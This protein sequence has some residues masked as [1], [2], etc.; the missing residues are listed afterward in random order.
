MREN[1]SENRLSELRKVSLEI[2]EELT[3]CESELLELI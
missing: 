3:H 2:G 1:R